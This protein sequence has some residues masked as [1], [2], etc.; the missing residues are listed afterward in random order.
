MDLFTVHF[1]DIVTPKPGFAITVANRIP[2]AIWALL[3]P[4]MVDKYVFVIYKRHG[5]ER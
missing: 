1:N 3:E 2:D 5:T 4:L